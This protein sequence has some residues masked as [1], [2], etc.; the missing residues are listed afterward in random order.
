MKL[1]D[2]EQA[3]AVQ[4]AQREP[5]RVRSGLICIGGIGKHGECYGHGPSSDCPYCITPAA[6]AA[7]PQA[8]E[9]TE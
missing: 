6:V 2:E 4:R 7:T 9:K 8:G 1:S 5:R 3:E